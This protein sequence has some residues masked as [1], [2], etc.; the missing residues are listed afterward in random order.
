MATT[1]YGSTMRS[2]LQELLGVDPGSAIGVAFEASPARP[3]GD[4][5]MRTDL[6]FRN[7]LGETVP[8]I[9]L[10]PEG[11]EVGG[12]AVICM[13]GTSGDAEQCAESTFRKL[14][15]SG[16]GRGVLCG[17]GAELTRRTGL[18]TLSLTLRGHDLRNGRTAE[19]SGEVGAY[20]AQWGTQMKLLAP[21]GVTMMG[22]MVD[23]VLRGVE[24]LHAFDC[25]DP[26]RI[27]VT[28]F[29]LGGNIA[30]YSAA[31]SP[32]IAASAPLCGGLGS[33]RTQIEDGD[34]D[35]HSAYVCAWRLCFP[36]FPP[37]LPSLPLQCCII[38]LCLDG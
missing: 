37:R 7:M 24:V 33:M 9:A 29:S 23:E 17:W 38:R 26:Q 10:A 2:K 18:V 20:E 36:R 11:A 15:P 16:G 28:G 35:R 32:R 5:L 14:P 4:D 12:G 13:A 30:W 25:V 6:S 21:L 22:V 3:Y 31:C 34:P 8:A 19:D 27:A 1:A